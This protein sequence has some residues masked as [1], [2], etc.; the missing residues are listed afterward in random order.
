[1]HLGFDQPWN[2]DQELQDS[3]NDDAPRGTVDAQIA[4]E[5]V[6]AVIQQ[7]GADA[8]DN[9]NGVDDLANGGG[10]KGL[11]RLKQGDHDR[12]RTKEDWLE[13]H[14]TGKLDSERAV[15]S[16]G[17]AVGEDVTRTSGA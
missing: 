5:D 17:A 16:L 11:A 7:G 9:R 8:S 1:M 2:L 12:G 15:T 4:A 3:A 13:Q 14:D 10:D 6:V